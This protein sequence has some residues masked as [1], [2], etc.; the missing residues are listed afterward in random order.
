MAAATLKIPYEGLA[1]NAEHVAVLDNVLDK[2]IFKIV[3][4]DYDDE[5]GQQF[6]DDVNTYFPA[7]VEE[8]RKY[9]FGAEGDLGNDDDEDADDPNLNDELGHDAQNGGA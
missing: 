4:D 2:A 8:G 5:D 6:K 1:M 3:A 9:F 7:M